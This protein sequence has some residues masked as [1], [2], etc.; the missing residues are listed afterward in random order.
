MGNLLNGQV[1]VVTG[2]GNGI[3]RA[4]AIAFA[5][6]G[7]GV[8]VNDIGT[9]TD[10]IGKTNSN[11]DQVVEEIKKA[12]GTA[13]ANYDSVAE[14]EGANR[15]IQTA[16]DKFGRLDILVNNA[17]IIRNKP[18]Y[19]TVTKDWDAVIKTH[20][21]GTMYCTR[22]ASIIMKQQRYGRIINT[23]SHVG[24]GAASGATY[25]AAKEGIV[26]FS[27]SVARDMGKFGVTCNV[28]RPLALWRGMVNVDENMKENRTDDI[29]VLVVYLASKQADNV[30]GCIF[31]VWKGRIGIFV[32]PPPVAQVIWKDGNW[33]P[34]ELVKVMPETLTAGKKREEF[35]PMMAFKLSPPPSQK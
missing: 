23:S 30:N 26:G 35:P 4:E 14:E 20:L 3:G 6:E 12:G 13:F 9:S 15:I 25:S 27:R 18:I 33:S 21:Y 7:A 17:G 22:A 19:E 32:E 11:A 34:E 2:S 5:A 31:E 1:A 24:L 16:I 8:I 29:A 10:G 28:I